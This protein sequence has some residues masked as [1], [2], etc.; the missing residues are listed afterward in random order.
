MTRATLFVAGAALVL[1]L[2]TPAAAQNFLFNS[3]ETINQGNFKLGVYPAVLLG[4]NGDE[5]SWGVTTRL[6]YGFTHSFDVEAKA[7]FYDGFKMYG[8]DAEYWVLKGGRPDVSVSAGF[9]KADFDSGIDSTA[10]DVA[11]IVSGKI[12]HNL[13]LYGGL[14]LSFESLDNVPDSSFTRVY[15]VPGLEYSVHRNVDL[16]AEVGLG[17]NDDSP[18]YVGFGVSLYL[19]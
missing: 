5:D 12:A 14:S 18:N 4:K 13:D 3:A 10:W 16:L 19:R 6:G 9:H 15:V 2:A 11:G 1:C 8:A 7:N 17:L